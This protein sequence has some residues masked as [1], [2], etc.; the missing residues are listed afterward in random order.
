MLEEFGDYGDERVQTAYSVEVKCD[1]VQNPRLQF[2]IFCKGPWV[3]MAYE[4][5]G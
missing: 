4:G 5:W 3:I 2:S 1:I